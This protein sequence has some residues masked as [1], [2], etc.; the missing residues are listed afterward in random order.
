MAV[1]ND[2]T[3]DVNRQHPYSTNFRCRPQDKIH[4]QSAPC[5]TCVRKFTEDNV[6]ARAGSELH[7]LDAMWLQKQERH[8]P[9]VLEL[10]RISAINTR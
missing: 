5:K 3:S 8:C 2:K 7:S 6:A 9:A 10:P 4:I 1:T